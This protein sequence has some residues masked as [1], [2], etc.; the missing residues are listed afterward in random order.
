MK[1]HLLFF[2]S[3]SLV[4]F[5]CAKKEPSDS[6]QTIDFSTDFKPAN[7]KDKDRLE[8]MKAAFP[9]IDKIFQEH[10]E[11]NHFPGMAYGIVADGQL[12]YSNA[13]GVANISSNSLSTSQTAFRIASMSKSFTALSILKLRDEG[14]LSLQDPVSKYIPELGKV[15]NLTKDSPPIIIEHLL[16]MAAGFPEDNPW[17]DRQLDDTE[18]YQQYINENILTPLGMK[19]SRWEY[20]EVPKEQLATGYRWEDEQWKEEPFLHDGA[21]GAMGGLICSVE[22]FS[23]YLQ[24]HLS[25]WPPRNEEESSIIKR[26]SLREMH[27]L[28]RFGGLFPDAKTRSGELCP[29]INGYGYGLGYR[30]DCKD[31]VSIRHGGGLPGFG[32]EWRFFPD[33]GIGIVSLSNLTYGGMGSTNAKALDTLIYIANLKP[34]TLPVSTILQ[35]RQNEIVELIQSWSVEKQ[36]ILAENFLLDQSLEAWK[37]ATTKILGE[38]GKIIRINELIPENQLRGIF[39]IEGEK[40]N[41]EVFFTLTPEQIPLIQQLDLTLQEKK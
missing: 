40:K 29:V 35:Q 17:G 14:R 31:V 27:Q 23:K 24:L 33:L 18:P 7:F 41:I 1:K 34:R 9:V 26:S 16:T 39:V 13:F 12:M 8:K 10:L 20:S 22:D 5:G 28:Q 36:N 6:T 15:K 25:A 37:K 4:V 3:V 2:I 19:D 21:Y 32:S 11:K 30:R 38:A